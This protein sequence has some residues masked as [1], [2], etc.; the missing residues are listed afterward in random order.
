LAQ[1][2]QEPKQG[3]RHTAPEQGG[4]HSLQVHDG[5]YGESAGALGAGQLGS[6]LA[7]QE[8]PHRWLPLAP[9]ALDLELT[10]NREETERIEQRK[11]NQ[12]KS[13]WIAPKLCIGHHRRVSEHTP[14]DH[15][16]ISTQAM[17]NFRS[18]PRTS[19]S[20]KKKI[21]LDLDAQV[22]LIEITW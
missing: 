7:L 20:S 17:E 15:Q 5:S 10:K 18:K 13:K 19:F 8:D 3:E 22:E 12:T 2:T 21:G 4:G 16:P 1:Q 14:R 11:K 9:E 6:L